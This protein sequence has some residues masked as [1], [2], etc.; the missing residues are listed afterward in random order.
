MSEARNITVTIRGE[1]KRPLPRQG[2]MWQQH[3]RINRVLG[4]SSITI[5][6]MAERARRLGENPRR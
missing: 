1:L 6:E 3:D 2:M 5:E 4:L